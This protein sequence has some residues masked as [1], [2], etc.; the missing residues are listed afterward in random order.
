MG[1]P[2]IVEQPDK[3]WITRLKIKV[4]VRD[5]MSL[6]DL[7]TELDVWLAYQSENLMSG[8]IPCE[9]CG[10]VF[11]RHSGQGF[12]G[13][14]ACPHYSKEDSNN[15][16]EDRH[17]DQLEGWNPAE[18]QELIDEMDLVPSRAPNPFITLDDLQ[19]E[20]S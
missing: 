9:W 2:R 20:L 19:K 4:M 11:S 5:G 6:S 14:C 10:H 17:P 12:C 16:W 8:D 15:T 3:H 13:E 1:L 18:Y 7:L